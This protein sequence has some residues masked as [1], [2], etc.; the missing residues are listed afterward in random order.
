M[1][2]AAKKES[3]TEY[4]K[5]MAK[6]VD[7]KLEEVLKREASEQYLSNLL[8]RSGYKYD[9]EA[10]TKSIF[11]PAWYL[12]D[13]GGKRLRAVLMLTVIDALGKNPA[14]FIEFSLIPEVIHNGTLVHDDIEDGSKERRGYP[15][16]HTAFGLDI[17]LNL[18]DFM[19]YFPIIALIDTK[20]IDER[21]KNRI[22]VIYGREM[23]RIAI[24][25]A[26]DLAW[27]DNLVDPHSITEEKYLQM[28]FGKTGT[29]SS[30]AA[31]F[32][33][34]ICEAD[35]STMKALARFG[36]TLG[37]AFQIQ[38]DLLNIIPSGVSESKGGVGDDIT[39]GKMTLFVI[40]AMGHAPKKEGERL[41]EILKMHTPDKKLIDEAIYIIKRSGAI[42]YAKELQRQFVT[43]A[44]EG[45]DKSLKD[46]DA[47]ARLKEILQFVAGRSI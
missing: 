38:D 41:I 4:L 42:E 19:Y 31:Q 8:G 44:W 40:Y 9:T 47:K 35:E 27:H 13:K 16:V 25:Q 24:G 34:A 7:A 32:A 23:T 15:C 39:E 5:R 22:L 45:I 18:G 29:L 1:N 37:V 30:M 33:G 2:S 3:L 6:S 21:I 43:D 10:I 14:D 12:L 11:E 36:A 46:S 28:V 17:A 20:K 26:T